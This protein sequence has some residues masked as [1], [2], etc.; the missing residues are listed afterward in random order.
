[1]ANTFTQIHVQTVFCVENRY[2]LI[3]PEWKDE[4]YK[5][6]TGIIQKNG[7]KLLIINGMPDHIHLFFGF[8]PTQSLSDLMQEV[9]AGSSKWI[10]E[11]KFI[12]EKFSWQAGYGGFSYSKSH[13]EKVIDYI[14]N[15][16]RHH[17][18]KTFIQEYQEMLDA[19]G[20][21]YEERFLFK[22]IEIA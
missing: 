10:N 7:H 14:K 5:Y 16:E 4:L 19:F 17:L 8:R 9:K 21:D 11:K 15:Q 20:I 6:I 18:K 22:P 2:S 3:K 12:Q 13:V 1:M